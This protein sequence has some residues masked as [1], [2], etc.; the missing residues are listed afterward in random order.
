MAGSGRGIFPDLGALAGGETIS[1]LGF[2]LALRRPK[3]GEPNTGGRVNVLEPGA[4]T[5][6]I[7][8][9][10]EESDAAL[11]GWRYGEPAEPGCA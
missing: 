8:V 4:V 9:E 7:G 1:S 11:G 10:T 6:D 2:S 5:A 3:S